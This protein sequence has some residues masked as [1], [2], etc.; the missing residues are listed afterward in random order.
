MPSRYPI[1]QDREKNTILF[2]FAIIFILV[3]FGFSFSFLLEKMLQ[4][5]IS[6]ET[7]ILVVPAHIFDFTGQNLFPRVVLNTH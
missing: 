2:G 6:K 4:G 3:G 1:L 7:R 5:Y